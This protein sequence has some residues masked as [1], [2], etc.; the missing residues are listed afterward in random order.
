MGRVKQK[1]TKPELVVR[2]ILH[3]LGYRYRLHRKDL[4]G[5]PDI[6]LP[7]YRTVIFV[8]GCFWHKHDC[9]RGQ[10]VPKTRTEYWVSKIQKNV[11][12]DTKAYASLS[13]LGWKILVIWE[14]QTRDNSKLVTLLKQHFNIPE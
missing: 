7:K 2:S 12:R 8:N 13:E 10:S 14:C 9:R 3:C 5:T 4:P 1:D 11:E 6:T